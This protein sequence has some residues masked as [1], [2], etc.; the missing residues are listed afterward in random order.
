MFLVSFRF[1]DRFS[2]FVSAAKLRLVT[3]VFVG[4]AKVE[5]FLVLSSF[6]SKLFSFVYL[7]TKPS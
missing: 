7:V 4:T 3:P 5:I 2:L 1:S 6:L